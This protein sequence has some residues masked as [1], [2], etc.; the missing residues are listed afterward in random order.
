[1][2]DV[3]VPVTDDKKPRKV[4]VDGRMVDIMTL[5]NG[6][7]I[8]VDWD[9][10]LTYQ[11]LDTDLFKY[12]TKTSTSKKNLNKS[13][14]I[15]LLYSFSKHLSHYFHKSLA[16][17]DTL[18]ALDFILRKTYRSRKSQKQY[19]LALKLY[20]LF[21]ILKQ[22]DNAWGA[23]GVRALARE[24]EELKLFRAWINTCENMLVEQAMSR[25]GTQKRQKRRNFFVQP[26][27]GF[28]HFGISIRVK[29]DKPTWMHEREAEPC[30]SCGHVML[31]VVNDPEEIRKQN[32]I[33]FKEYE[34]ALLQWYK[35]GADP[36]KQPKQPKGSMEQMLVCMCCVSLCV[37]SHTGSGCIN[38]KEYVKNSPD[39]MVP[40]D[41][42][43]AMCT[44]GPCRC[45]CGVYFP[46]SKWQEVAFLAVEERVNKEKAQA[47]K[48]VEKQ[49]KQYG[50]CAG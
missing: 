40:R 2:P 15:D 18:Q 1:M 42:A 3:P 23:R 13:Q 22:S 44:C 4:E 20:S 34:L 32:E 46:R 6:V 11:D 45:K 29:R 37:D 19:A 36:K 39:G 47:A 12:M 5:D 27:G 16:W 17:L 7:K 50:E 9:P 10:I 35:D 28:S 43:T 30:P 31:V 38:C 48:V 41:P 21:K 24:P 8:T 26:G 49:K 25:S 14:R 33:R